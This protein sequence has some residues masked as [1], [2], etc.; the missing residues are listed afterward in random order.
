MSAPLLGSSV[1]ARG[2]LVLG[3][4]CMYAGAVLINNN[5][6]FPWLEFEN[7][8]SLLFLP[9]GLKL[10]LVM[11]L[12]WRAVLGIALGIWAVA[13]SEFPHMS[14]LNG[15]LLGAV[16][17]LSTQVAL[18]TVARLL[19]VGY[20]WTA[21]GW[22]SLCAIALAVGCVDATLVQWSMATLGYENYDNFW[23]EALQGAFGRVIG[24]FIF[25]AVSL[26]VRRHLLR[27]EA[28]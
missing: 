2:S 25:L 21:L 15:A 14:M 27:N 5:L 28:E 13:V 6:L 22:R 1:L 17:A 12:G 20:P 9:A 8:R 11:V 7:F 4:A 26:E 16:A 24:T 10:F 18:Q 19:R 23:T 3:I